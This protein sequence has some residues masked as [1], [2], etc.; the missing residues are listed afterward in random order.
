VNPFIMDVDQDFYAVLGV[1]R[2]APDAAIRQAF[3]ARAKELHPDSK[4]A[5]DHEADGEDFRLLTEAYETL[6]DPFRRRTYDDELIRNRQVAALG[7]ERSS[8]AFAKGLGMGLFV[9]VIAIAGMIYANR[10]AF[11]FDSFKNQESL[12]LP[13]DDRLAVTE[14]LKLGPRAFDDDGMAGGLNRPAAADGGETGVPAPAM[15]AAQPLE[16]Q[17]FVEQ[18]PAGAGEADGATMQQPA[19]AQSPAA[20]G[21]RPQTIILPKRGQAQP[22]AFAAAV[23]SLE[24]TL[25]SEGNSV[26]AYRLTTLVNSSTAISELVEAASVARQPGTQDLIS[27]R[28][29]ALREEQALSTGGAPGL[30]DSGAATRPRPKAGAFEI[31]VGPRA[32]ETILHLTPGN[33]LSESFSDCLDCPEMVVIPGGQ[34]VMGSRPEGAGFRPEEAPAHRIAIKKPIAISKHWVTA[35]NWRACVE[36]GVCRPTISSFLAAGSEVPATRVSW[37]DSK[38]YVDWLSQTTG[39]HYRLLSEAEWEYAAQAQGH[40]GAGSPLGQDA[41][42]RKA[43]SDFG[44]LRFGKYKHLGGAKPNVW[45]LHAIPG[46][47]LEWVE[48][49]WHPNYTQAPADG[50]PW[51]AAAG[52]DCAYRMVRG[53]AAPGGE[54]EERRI[55][56]RAREF[57]DARSPTL[58]FRV[59]RELSAPAKAAPD[60]TAGGRGKTARGD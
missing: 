46:N 9:A 1:P 4:L 11:R 59:A 18:P 34:A 52:G 53:G 51:L 25:A 30:S 32:R 19:L 2:D 39:R 29:A 7:G 58:G 35:G 10:A 45:G 8:H 36:A 42:T 6:K 44:I 50:S 43:A 21:D 16:S 37:F 56:V 47:A 3:R 14:A 23:L 55:A 28:I 48:D 31:A 13:K 20:T 27:A 38:A 33:G 26:A 24:G 54:F 57:A 22:S 5:P 15:P 60:A 41:A 40:H 12:R 49:C 17:G